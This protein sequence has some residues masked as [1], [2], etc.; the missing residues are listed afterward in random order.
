MSAQ[1]EWPS[2][3]TPP[4]FAVDHSPPS[5][6]PPGPKD[7]PHAPVPAKD[8]QKWPLPPWWDVL[9]DG[10]WKSEIDREE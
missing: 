10:T 3:Q 9:F 2:D 5:A 4:D 1:P 8:Y 7:R 6:S